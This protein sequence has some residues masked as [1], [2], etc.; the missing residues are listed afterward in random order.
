MKPKL[1]DYILSEFLLLLI[2]GATG[3]VLWAGR[4]VLRTALGDF[5][6]LGF[7]LLF[8]L[9][10]GGFTSAVLG[11]FAKAFPLR[12]GDYTTDDTPFTLWKVTHVV[13]ELGKISLS[14]FFPV[15]FRPAFYALF[16][17][18]VGKGVAVSCKI[19]DPRLTILEDGCV[20]GEGCVLTSHALSRGRFIIGRIRVG[21]N[22]IIGIGTMVMPG[23]SVGVGAVILPGSVLTRNTV[24]PPGET[25]GGVPA[26]RVKPAPTPIE[27]PATGGVS[28]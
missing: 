9:L 1:R 10:Y 26:V 3:S 20:L 21:R 14:I 17:A 24:V 6:L 18:T 27:A 11:L 28:F 23:V 13:E 15:F 12:D 22:A 19:L 7:V 8:L 25:W 4:G 2:L 16:G 5:A